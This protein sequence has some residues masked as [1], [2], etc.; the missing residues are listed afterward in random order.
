MAVHGWKLQL[1][2]IVQTHEIFYEK[3]YWTSYKKSDE[4]RDG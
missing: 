4:N 2:D 1:P 3:E